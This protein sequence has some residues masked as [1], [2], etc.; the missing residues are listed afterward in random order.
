MCDFEYYPEA[1]TQSDKVQSRAN[2]N[3]PR[4]NWCIM[5]FLCSFLSKFISQNFCNDK[6]KGY[7]CSTKHTHYYYIVMKGTVKWFDSKKGYGFIVGEDAK[8]TFVHYT[9]IIKDG[10]KALSEG[11]TVEYE[12]ENCDKGE[13]AINVTVVVAEK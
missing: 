5:S 12:I 11:Q 3:I 4:S 13:Q 1:I 10:F 8:E 9:G 7:L 6:N 2:Y